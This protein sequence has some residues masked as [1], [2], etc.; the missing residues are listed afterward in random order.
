MTSMMNMSYNV[1]SLQ[2]LLAME[3]NDKRG[4]LSGDILRYTDHHM[5]LFV[6][7]RGSLGESP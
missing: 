2:D 4:L 3:H 7:D 1:A 6:W 5:L